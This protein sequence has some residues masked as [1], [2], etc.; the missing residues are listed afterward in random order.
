MERV[1][2]RVLKAILWLNGYATK[3]VVSEE[4]DAEVIAFSNAILAE[5]GYPDDYLK[6][7]ER[8]IKNSVAFTVKYKGNLIGCLRLID[9]AG[10]C[11]ILDF[12][13]IVFPEYVSVLQAR[14]MGS[15]VI[16]KAHRGRSRWPMTAL[17]DIAYDY[18][19]KNNI[20]WW[21]A[22]AYRVKFEKFKTMNPSCTILEMAPPTK[23]QLE[24]RE[25]YFDF[26]DK[27]KTA[28]IFVFNLEGA[29]YLHQFKRILKQK[30]KR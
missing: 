23:H 19:G 11:R 18:S 15:L 29:S 17:L 22:S 12:W 7:L 26:F 27:A 30:F 2:K 6:M 14:E 1:L 5:E 10:P 13:N 16:D 21:F 8:Y 25:R 4:E 9:P 24:Y 20:N 28:V 3:Q